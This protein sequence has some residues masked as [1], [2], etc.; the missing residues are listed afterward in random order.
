MRRLLVLPLFLLISLAAGCGTGFKLPTEQHVAVVP[1]NGTYGLIDRWS[2]LSNIRDLV[3]TKADVTSNEQLFVLFSTAGNDTGKVRAYATHSNT[4]FSYQYNGMINPWALCA[5]ATRLFVLDQGDTCLARAVRPSSGRC[6]S[7]VVNFQYY[8]HVREYFPDG[9]DTISTF[10]D[11]TMA[12]VQGIAVDNL[13][14]IYVSGLYIL[15]TINPDNPFLYYRRLVWQVNR[16]LRGAGD[17]NM[18]GSNWH[19]D[20]TYV[21]AEGSG[22]GTVMNP[23]GLDW[24]PNGS[25]ALYLSDTANNRAQ[26]LGDPRSGDD[27]L[28]LDTDNGPLTSPVDVCAD[29]AGF[30]Y[31][32][33]GGPN[34]GV[35]RYQGIG[36]GLSEMVQRVDVYTDVTTPR[37]LQPVAVTADSDRVYVADAGRGEVSIF[38]RRR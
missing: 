25:G 5:T 8:W 27:Y 14:R 34:F 6:D 23:Q 33:N 19:R 31:V 2:G 37:L 30:A 32:V 15:V 11:T 21:L 12:W 4:Q 26:R 17:P 22:L 35:F 16:Y 18:P 10:T 1:G 36:Q 7:N 20:P 3:L 13:Q 38:Q 9:G 28:M 29:L 24:S